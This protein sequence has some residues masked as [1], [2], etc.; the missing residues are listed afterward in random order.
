MSNR[1]E[2]KK[3]YETTVNDL[4]WKPIYPNNILGNGLEGFYCLVIKQDKNGEYSGRKYSIIFQ[5]E[6]V[7]EGTGYINPNKTNAYV[8]FEKS[9]GKIVG[10]LDY[11]NPSLDSPSDLWKSNGNTLTSGDINDYGTFI[12][13]YKDIETAKKRALSQYKAIYGYIASHFIED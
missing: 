6:E 11:P 7:E 1:E 3:V 9:Y 13:A 2:I 8:L 5:H 10:P 12:Y 4:V